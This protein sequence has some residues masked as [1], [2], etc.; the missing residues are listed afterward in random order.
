MM[1]GGVN[2]FTQEEKDL[3]RETEGASDSIEGFNLKGHE[4][5]HI[6]G[7]LNRAVPELGIA[8]KGLFT[9]A[10]PIVVVFLAL[11]L[12]MDSWHEAQEN[13]KA[14]AEALGTSLDSLR[15]SSHNALEEIDKFNTA[16]ANSA[17]PPPAYLKGLAD[18]E[19]LLSAT[20]E[21][22]KKLIEIE[23][24]S[25]L[26][27]AQTPAEKDAVR[28]RYSGFK[29]AISQG[30]DASKI[31]ATAN[32]RIALE[33]QKTAIEQQVAAIQNQLSDLISRSHKNVP[34][35]IGYGETPG[36]IENL[37]HLAG[38]VTD[39]DIKKAQDEAAKKIA[40]LTK[41]MDELNKQSAD[42][43]EKYRSDVGTGTIKSTGHAE[44]KILNTALPGS[45]RTFQELESATGKSHQQQE[46]LLKGV[47][48]HTLNLMTVMQQMQ[49][50]LDHQAK[51]LA[52]Q[53]NRPQG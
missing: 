15:T 43:A 36:D 17:P 32:A 40:E 47:L 30:E 46:N 13:A 34:V 20:Y 5:R 11:K 27:N 53:R 38:N 29:D 7:L 9:D 6:V 22:K 42:L 4:M 23:E 2:K 45:T 16:V 24:Q 39:S 19:K 33:N 49:W 35:N 3:K 10:G 31:T 1:S 14:S 50:Q 41:T 18:V 51:M 48:N 28:A 8:M 21:V 44:E 12:A 52:N 37:Q 25:E 26:K